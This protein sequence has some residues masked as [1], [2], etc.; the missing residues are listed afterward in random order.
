MNRIKGHQT[1][2]KK[3]DKKASKLVRKAEDR[4]MLI[5]RAVRKY[6]DVIQTSAEG[7]SVKRLR[8]QL[9][10]ERAVVRYNEVHKA[11]RRLRKKMILE[12]K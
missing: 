2:S 3:L 12:N 9:D 6:N 1:M 5:R 4:A 8:G 10:I 11:I 7:D